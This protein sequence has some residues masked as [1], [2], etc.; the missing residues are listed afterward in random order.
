VYIDVLVIGSPSIETI[1]GIFRNH[2]ARF[3][4]AFTQNICYQN[5]LIAKINVVM[6]A[7]DK[8]NDML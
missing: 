6:Y 3:F 5:S 1:G 7:I 8:A 4:V 2:S